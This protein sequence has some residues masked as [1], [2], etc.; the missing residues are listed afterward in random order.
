[1]IELWRLLRPV[2]LGRTALPPR[3]WST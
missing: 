2:L 3:I 1:L